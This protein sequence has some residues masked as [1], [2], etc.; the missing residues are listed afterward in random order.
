M[1]RSRWVRR[2]TRMRNGAFER[3]SAAWIAAALV[4]AMSLVATIEGGASG[5]GCALG[6]AGTGI[7]GDTATGKSSAVGVIASMLGAGAGVCG[8]TAR[9]TDAAAEAGVR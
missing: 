1:M 4:P 3:G 2:V 8:G 9:A 7:N 5:V 6:A